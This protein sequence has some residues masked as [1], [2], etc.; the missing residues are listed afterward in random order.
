M[1]SI[2]SLGWIRAKSTIVYE[3]K[4]SQASSFCSEIDTV[5]ME[6]FT[7]VL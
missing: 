5:M 3:T 7:D 6:D 2:V 4:Q 1:D